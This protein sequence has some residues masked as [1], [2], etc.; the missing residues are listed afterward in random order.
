VADAA[1]LGLAFAI[2]ELLLGTGGSAEQSAEIAVFLATLPVW[3]ALAWI[4]SLYGR[5]QERIEHSTLDDL[6]G[7]AQTVTVGV[8]AFGLASWLALDDPGF[9]K[10]ASLWGLAIVLVISARAAARSFCRTRPGF[11]QN[12]AVVG[13]DEVGQL[14][15]RKLLQHPEYG[16]NVVGFADCV[17]RTLRPEVEHVPLLGPPEGLPELT[18][19]LDVDRIVV[20]FP[21]DSH[22]RT[23][24]LVRALDRL[25]VQVEVVPRLFELVGPHAALH[26][27]EGLPLLAVGSTRISPVARA[28]KRGLDLVGACAC[29]VLAAPLL[30]I[31]AVLVRL[32][33]P[34]PVLFR[35]TR[36]GLGM[37]PFTM[38]KLR[39]MRADAD[40]SAHRDYIRATA[41]AATT[42][43]PATNGL[44][45]LERS[46]DVT[47]LGRLLRRT[48]LDELP[49]LL[50]VLRG[51]MSL[52][53]PRPCIPYE[54]E[55]FA[56]HHFERFG[57]PSGITGLW[58]VTAR[59]RATFAEALDLDVQYARGWTLGL[60]VRL[61]LRTV[62]QLARLGAAA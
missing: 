33:S 12:V 46:G 55:H 27:V 14:V 18:R 16:L 35:Q 34:G 53:G 7:V 23:L 15:A 50:N 40:D 51:E 11:V 17:R 32:D 13:S 19:E 10:L 44:Y 61:L 56:P 25:D 58:Q 36:L 59:S 45:K 49:Q 41:G 62:R 48:S 9:V 54:V 47:R 8:W 4:Q 20:A 2:V 42:A 60:D 28:A 29:L 43:A 39:T 3:V 1:G 22:E 24:E 26:A 6:A 57:V 30:A 21:A 52:V 31:L 37:Q 38:L 5:D